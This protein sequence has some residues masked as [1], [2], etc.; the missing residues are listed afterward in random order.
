MRVFEFPDQAQDY[1][2][3]FALPSK[4]Y[5]LAD[6]CLAWDE[7]GAEGGCCTRLSP[8]RIIQ[9]PTDAPLQVEV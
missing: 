7:E 6:D 2:C 8:V 5:C 9:A 1:Y 3:P 4:L